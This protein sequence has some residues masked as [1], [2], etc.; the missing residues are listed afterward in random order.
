MSTVANDI[1]VQLWNLYKI[2]AEILN[3]K[4][5]YTPIRGSM[6][7]H[8]SRAGS[9]LLDGDE[10]QKDAVIQEIKNIN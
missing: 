5:F 6:R 10:E 2:N 9:L 8:R 1:K 4:D 3:L 7:R